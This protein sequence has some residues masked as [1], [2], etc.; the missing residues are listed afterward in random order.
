MYDKILMPNDGSQKTKRAINEAIKIAKLSGAELHTV[1][2][3]D[4]AALDSLPETGF[5]NQTKDM[6][7]KE[8]I[9]ANKKVKEKSKSHGVKCVSSILSG[10]PHEKII[11]YADENNIDL[12]VMGTSSKKGMEKFLLGSVAEKVLRSSEKPVLVVRGE[13]NKKS[14]GEKSKLK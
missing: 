14:K 2:V 1:F 4:T 10:K 3:I 6:L 12:I 7:N 11:N 9:E 5:W 13:S 8:G